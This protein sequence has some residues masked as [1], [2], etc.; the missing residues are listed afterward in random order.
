MSPMSSAAHTTG[1]LAPY[2]AI[3]LLLLWPSFGLTPALALGGPTSASNQSRSPA[4][5]CWWECQQPSGHSGSTQPDW[6]SSWLEE[7]GGIPVKPQCPSEPSTCS[8]L[9]STGSWLALTELN[10]SLILTMRLPAL[11][12]QSLD[13]LTRYGRQTH[14]G[15]LALWKMATAMPSFFMKNCGHAIIALAEYVERGIFMWISSLLYL[16]WQLAQIAPRR[17]LTYLVLASTGFY[18]WTSRISRA[19]LKIVF[20][21]VWLLTML[22]PR[23]LMTILFSPIASVLSRSKRLLTTLLSLILRKKKR[24]LKAKKKLMKISSLTLKKSR[25]LKTKERALNGYKPTFVP[26]TLPR[27]VIGEALNAQGLRVGYFSCVKLQGG[28][29][30][31]MTPVHV[32]KHTSTFQGPNGKIAK[33]EAKIVMG[34]KSLDF[35][36]FEGPLNWGSSMGM[37]A[38]PLLPADRVSR[39]Q[40]ILYVCRD[41]EWKAQ[42]CNIL[43]FNDDGFISTECATTPGD[44]GLPIFDPKGSRIMAMHVGSYME[45]EC[46]RAT[47]IPPIPNMTVPDTQYYKPVESLY[48]ANKLVDLQ[49]DFDGHDVDVVVGDSLYSVKVKKGAISVAKEKE[50]WV[51]KYG[52]YW[53]DI[54]DDEDFESKNSQGRPPASKI[55]AENKQPEVVTAATPPP[56]EARPTTPEGLY[57][58]PPKRERSEKEHARRARSKARRAAKKTAEARPPLGSLEENL[59]GAIDLNRLAKRV[60]DMIF[61]QV[62]SRTH[63]R[64]SRNYSGTSTPGGSQHQAPRASMSSESARSPSSK[65]RWAASPS[66]VKAESPTRHSW[67]TAASSSDGPKPGPTPN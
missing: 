44:S 27:G 45:K 25:K 5:S 64:P 8:P 32:W 3:L 33:D 58:P 21:P 26:G 28:G 52:E 30:A 49:E 41:D 35:L 37:S 19:I 60:E 43:A 16:L 55:G 56:P 67:R 23:F 50:P 66:G 18:C 20:L 7:S 65:V 17:T 10:G 61:Q 38:K 42:V 54:E 47:A 59:L 24:T 36:L 62:K 51:P 63:V 34:S 4:V 12:P 57:V 39:G 22:S 29:R 53:G 13:Y 15:L 40:H 48:V 46:N 31:L 6:A 1:T 9:L 2:L 11:L 14:N